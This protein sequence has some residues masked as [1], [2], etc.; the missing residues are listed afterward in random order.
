M[1]TQTL[2]IIVT[3]TALSPLVAPLA[4]SHHQA[5]AERS[6]SHALLRAPAKRL[7]REPLEKG[8]I[9]DYVSIKQEMG[10]FAMFTFQINSS[11]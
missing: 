3:M 2:T 6:L 10:E 5:P 11:V 4:A 7:R 1:T 9:S 8:M